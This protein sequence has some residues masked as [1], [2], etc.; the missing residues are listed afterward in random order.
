MP[1]LHSAPIASKAVYSL[2]MALT[3]KSAGLKAATSRRSVQ[4]KASKYAEELVKT[5]VS[6]QFCMQAGRQGRQISRA[7]FPAVWHHRRAKAALAA[8]SP[9]DLVYGQLNANVH[10]S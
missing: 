5:A 9:P 7:L 8:L 4:V 10:S 1:L 3:M 6:V 2:K